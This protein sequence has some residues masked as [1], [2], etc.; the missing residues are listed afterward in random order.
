MRKIRDLG[1]NVIPATMRPP[2]IGAG[3]AQEIIHACGPSPYPGRPLGPPGPPPGPRPG[4]EKSPGP[5]PGPG[6]KPYYNLGA[7][8]IAQIRE[9][10]NEA[11]ENEVVN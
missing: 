6:P 1:I 4:C 3:G 9:Q 2:E 5:G 8:A 7:E 10:L 11:I